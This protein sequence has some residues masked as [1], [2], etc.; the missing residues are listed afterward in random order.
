M[1]W[2][3]MSQVLQYKGHFSDNR[4]V[5]GKSYQVIKLM[6]DGKAYCAMYEDNGHLPKQYCCTFQV[7]VN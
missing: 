2:I 6:V 5:K 1:T 4:M 7:R 3:K